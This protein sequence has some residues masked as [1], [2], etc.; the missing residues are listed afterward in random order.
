MKLLG[1]LKTFLKPGLLI[2]GDNDERTEGAIDP[3]VG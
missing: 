1:T 2:S 3:I